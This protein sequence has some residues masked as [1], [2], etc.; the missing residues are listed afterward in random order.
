MKVL[1]ITTIGAAAFL[2]AAGGTLA[3]SRVDQPQLDGSSA[4]PA[5][6][7][8]AVEGK[9]VDL[10]RRPDMVTMLKLDNG[11]SLQVA[12]ESQGP[13]Q[14]AQVGDSITARYAEGGGRDKIATQV[15]VIETQAP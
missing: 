9:V 13:G 6:D 10:E 11:T 1:G 5:A 12:A 8:R 7:L 2:L 3:Q 14:P 4:E 15:R